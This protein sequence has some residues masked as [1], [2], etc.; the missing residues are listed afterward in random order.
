MINRLSVLAFLLSAALA[1]FAQDAENC[2]DSPLITRMP[3]ATIHNCEHKEFEQLDVRTGTDKDGEAIQKHLEGEYW[4]WD[5]GN[6]EGVSEI[7][8]FRNFETAL[9][10]AGFAIDWSG[11][12][13]LLTAHKGDTWYSLDNKGDF[14]YQY[15]VAVKA[16][17]Q[18]VT[19]DAAQLQDE[20]SKSGHVAVYGIHFETGKAAVLPDSEPVLA[21]VQK[22]LE[23]NASLKVRIEGHTDNVGQQDERARHGP[24]TEPPLAPPWSP[25]S[26]STCARPAHRTTLLPPPPPRGS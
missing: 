25:C 11:S 5:Y 6:R 8:V 12:P 26:A 16:M 14:Y 23:Q 21:E 1:A 9:R 18:E 19:A 15:I 10:K 24:T 17:Q 4:F 20:I 7:Q 3:G 13:N 2:K 22:L